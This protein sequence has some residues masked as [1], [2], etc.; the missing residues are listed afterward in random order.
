M[1]R[2]EKKNHLLR[3]YHEKQWICL[4]ST[5]NGRQNQRKKS[6]GRSFGYR[7]TLETGRNWILIL[8]LGERERK[9]NSGKLNLSR[10]LLIG[11]GKLRKFSLTD[12]NLYLLL[13]IIYLIYLRKSNVCFIILIFNNLRLLYIT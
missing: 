8:S 11:V 13:K 9:E 5:Y 12:L 3:T 10:S 4:S 2:E 1:P 6:V 7:W